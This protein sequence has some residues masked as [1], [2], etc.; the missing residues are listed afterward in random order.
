LNEQIKDKSP[1]V[2]IKSNDSNIVEKSPASKGYIARDNGVMSNF[3]NSGNCMYMHF[4]ARCCMHG[5]SLDPG[6][7]RPA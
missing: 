2:L 1:C 6:R 5:G 7:S 4:K 3:I